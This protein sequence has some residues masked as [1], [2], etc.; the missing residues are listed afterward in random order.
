[1]L[2]N[3]MNRLVTSLDRFRGRPLT[4]EELIS[5]LNTMAGE[6][7][8]ISRSY[9][10][11]ARKTRN[12]ARTLEVRMKNERRYRETKDVR[13]KQGSITTTD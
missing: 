9:K 3:F 8:E 2:T 10:Q 4:A 12:K 5:T 11:M 7:E 13:D 6:M 1:M